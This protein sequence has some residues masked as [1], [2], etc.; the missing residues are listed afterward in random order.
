MST[1]VT[2][3]DISKQVAGGLDISNSTEQEKEQEQS[4]E[5]EQEQEQPYKLTIK[6]PNGST[7]P[8]MATAQET[9]YDLKQVVSE[10][11][12]TVEYTCF[13][14]TLNNVRLNDYLELGEIEHLEKDS[15][16]E[17]VEDVYTEREA[18]IHVVRLRDLLSAPVTANPTV[19]GL[20]AGASLFSTVKYPNGKQAYKDEIPK[21]I[22]KNKESKEKEAE[23]EENGDE[24]ELAIEVVKNH[25]FKGFVFDRVPSFDILSPTKS[26]KRLALPSCV[27]SIVLSGWNPVSR[28][29]QLK[30][31]LLYLLVTTLEGQ[32]YHITAS[33][34]GFYV[35]S[36]TMSRF[37]PDNLGASNQGSEQKKKLEDFYYAHSLVVLLRKLSPKFASGLKSLQQDI[38]EREPIESLPFMSG[39]D[40]AASPWLV[41]ADEN[42][43]HEKYDLSAPQEVYLRQGSQIADSMR[44]W[45]EE[46]QTIR[47]LPR[48]NL[49]ERVQRDRQFHKWNSEFTEVAVQ[50]A[51]SL[52]EGNMIPLNPT[53]PV[54]QHMYLRDNIFYSKGFDGRDTFTGLGGDAAAH[55]ATGKD[56]IG[57][58]IINQLGVDGINTLGS[59]VV[60]YRGVR[61]VAQSVVPG[62]FR[63]QDTTTQIVYGSVDNGTT[64]SADPE[65]H[66]LLEPVAKTLRFGEHAVTDAEG[67]EHKLYT[68]MDVKGLTGTDGR[69]YLLDLYRMTPVDVEFLEKECAENSDYP[70]KLV[71]LRPELIEIFWENSVRKAVHE[72]AIEKSKKTTTTTDDE[73][74]KE[75][76][77][78][79]NKD[80]TPA[81]PMSGFEFNM[82]FSPDAFT[83]SSV[84]SPEQETAVRNASKYLQET[85][86][87]ALVRDLTAYNSS[88][89]NGDALTA[90]M[91][92]RGINMRY[93]G[94][95]A[96]QL[97]SVE[98]NQSAK[99]VRRLV[100][101]EM[102]SRAVK[103]IVRDLLRVTPSHLHAE[104]FVLVLNLL[105][106]TG[107]CEEPAKHLSKEASTVKDLASMTP[108]SLVALIQQQVKQ[109][110]RYQLQDD[111]VGNLVKGNERILMRE[112][113]VKIGAQ[114]SLRDYYF[115]K[116]QESSI[117]GQ[118][119]SS[120]GLLEYKK[121]TKAAK[122]IVRDKVDQ[123]MDKKLAIFAD[124]VMN[125][126]A[127]T[128]SSAHHSS[129][130][131]EAFEA[132]RMSLEQGQ[133]ELGLEL[134]M[135]SLALHEQTFGFLHSE[136]ARCYAVV[137]L[138]HY[139]AG[140]FELAAEFMTRAV[141]ISERTVGV[142]HPLTIH[143]YLNL[144]LYEHARGYTLAALRLMHH[145]MDLWR[146]INS[147]DHPD[148]AI[149]Y[150]NIG[151][152]LQSLKQYPDALP[153]FKACVDIR[154]SLLGKDHV[155]VANSQHSLAK[156]YAIFGDF[157]SAA[158]TERDAYMF[159]S[160]NFGEEDPRTKETEGFLADFTL[161]AVR[162]AKLGK[163]AKEK[164]KEVA[165]ANSDL[166]QVNRADGKDLQ[167]TATNGETTAPSKGHLPIDELLK[168][169]SGGSSKGDGK[170]KPRRG[171]RGKGP[172]GSR[173]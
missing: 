89:L 153:F 10:S 92:Q 100:L 61:V 49:T 94:Q 149:A 42:S 62:I 91:H 45:N 5:Q 145:A 130:A 85:S 47:E 109:R 24:E 102:I 20:D 168:F 75:E 36:S 125:F 115:V 13:Y 95:I 158:K 38:Q 155:L 63:K 101:F 90:T 12:G 3:P 114:M 121:M 143:N 97:P 93:L 131:D 60:D 148:L 50:G 11:P 48:G 137:S 46:L 167:T 33:R 116:P 21:K 157:K 103:H 18:R 51:I 68:S 99:N 78:K 128:K 123:V 74:P 106:G 113:C 134:L 2:E 32:S 28:S 104:A 6:A 35:N 77:E 133:K 156:A 81:D 4:Q 8:I 59:V 96:T 172:K 154:S 164:I 165:A 159:F 72:Y 31:D 110:F 136:S 139:D 170:P 150:N 171:R 80:S 135:E 108:Q 142:D 69:K 82:E 112:V 34:T 87:P 25:A 146:L 119:V 27:R 73:Q 17:V 55:A 23:A 30:G 107:Y 151:V 71:L 19:A 141:I 173:H 161:H 65:F 66:K 76:A 166:I 132:G 88:P 105:V 52:V 54:D 56:I 124:D 64:I 140:E 144:A 44:D 127:V 43:V 129:F 70:H 138:A 39:A 9:I 41:R 118:I 16:L 117:Y 1:S 84:S 15:Q 40:Q 26:L 58:R 160:T 162:A 22:N 7:V 14:L 111:F 152:M 122:R 57:V 98:K 120:I 126:V 86:I 169:I 147:P 29:R 53:D 163:A 37:S 79:D 83:V 67:K